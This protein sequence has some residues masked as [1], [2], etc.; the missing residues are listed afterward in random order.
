MTPQCMEDIGNIPWNTIY[1]ASVSI[2]LGNEATKSA[3]KVHLTVCLCADVIQQASNTDN[4]RNKHA[5]NKQAIGKPTKKS[6]PMKSKLGKL[7][8]D[9][10][11]QMGRCV[12]LELYWRGNFVNKEL[13]DDIDIQW[14]GAWTSRSLHIYELYYYQQR[15]HS[16]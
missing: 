4:T 13:F 2:S 5:G 6:S 12:Y 15:W 8:T 3:G 1:Y 14:R 7:I 9:K 16:N 11:K 10:N